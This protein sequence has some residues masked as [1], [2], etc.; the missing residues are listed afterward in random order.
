MV[1]EIISLEQFGSVWNSL[2]HGGRQ[3]DD[4]RGP[5]SSGETT[6]AAWGGGNTRSIRVFE[7]APM[8]LCNLPLWS[9]LCKTAG[10][11]Q[12]GTVWNSLEQ[13]G[14]AAKGVHII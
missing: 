8:E 4:C 10:T 6:R 7:A 11:E 14:I 13:F 1:S 9:I 3:I 2:W 5:N 12:F